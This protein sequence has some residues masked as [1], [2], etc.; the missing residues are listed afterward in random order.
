MI[1]NLE[2]GKLLL[3]KKRRQLEYNLNGKDVEDTTGKTY[4][5]KQYAFISL[6]GTFSAQG[7]NK[8]FTETM[9][10]HSYSIRPGKG[11]TTTIKCSNGHCPC[12]CGR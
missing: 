3:R 12:C 8:I 6:Q 10:Q 1:V 11:T 5:C 7:L 9:F 2:S 4:L